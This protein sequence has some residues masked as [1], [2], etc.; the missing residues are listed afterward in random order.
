MSLPKIAVTTLATYFLSAGLA[1]GLPIIQDGPTYRDGI[2]TIPGVSTDAQVGKYQNAIFEMTAQGMWRLTSISTLDDGHPR[3]YRA[4][5]E[6]VEVIKSTG[7]PTQ[8]LL[9]VHGTFSSGCGS[10]GQVSQRRI[11]ER[12][13]ILLTD[14][15]TAYDVALCTAV[16]V[17]YIKTIPLDVYGLGAGTYIYDVNGTTGNFNLTADNALPGDCFGVSACQ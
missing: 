9:R 8:V 15:F 6:H 16:M 14:G 3:L 11:G 12:F 5:V 10:L 17:P 7:V 13:Q 2:L 4:P 1:L